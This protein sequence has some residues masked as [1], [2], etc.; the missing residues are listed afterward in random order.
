MRLR[1]QHWNAAKKALNAVQA[2]LL[3]FKEIESIST[4]AGYSLMTETEGANFGM[5]MINLTP[6]SE[7]DQTAAELIEIY[8]RP[9]LAYQRCGYSV[10]PASYSS[11]IR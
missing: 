1:E 3:P 7:R 9:H 6:W 4:L 11:G 10:L 2:A 8:K 5:G